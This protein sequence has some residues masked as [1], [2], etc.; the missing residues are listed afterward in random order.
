MYCPLAITIVF[1]DLVF[2]SVVFILRLLAAKTVF[3]AK[4]ARV[5]KV[6]ESKTVLAE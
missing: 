3:A 2:A 5:K 6:S 1:A 4:N